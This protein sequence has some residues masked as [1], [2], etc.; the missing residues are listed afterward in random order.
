MK[1]TTLLILATAAL[2]A[3][4]GCATTQDTA[5]KPETTAQAPA[6][7]KPVTRP[8]SGVGSYGGYMYRR[9]D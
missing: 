8:F 2:A 3:M 4:A 9:Y 7:D 6:L 1:K 5:Q